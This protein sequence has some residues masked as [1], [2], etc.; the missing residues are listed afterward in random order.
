LPKISYQLRAAAQL[1][2][3]VICEYQNYQMKI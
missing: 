3:R 1:L 2:Q